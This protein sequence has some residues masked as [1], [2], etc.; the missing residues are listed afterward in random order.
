MQSNYSGGSI[1]TPYLSFFYIQST[2]SDFHTERRGK[3][4]QMKVHKISLN[5]TS[6]KRCM[7]VLT[8]LRDF[9]VI[10]YKNMTNIVWSSF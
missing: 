3:S 10:E 4:I 6:Q 8:S 5:V 7:C 9:L 2:F 1:Q